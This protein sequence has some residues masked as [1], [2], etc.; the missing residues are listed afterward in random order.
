A[1]PPKVEEAFKQYCYI[2]YMALMHAA[3]SKAHLRRE[4][5]AFVFTQD[6]LT[7]K[8]L[9]RSN[10]LLIATVDW[11]AA[12]KA[13]EE[14]TLHYWG[15]DRSS[16]LT[17]HHL[18]VLDIAL[19]QSISHVPAW[20]G[21]QTPFKQILH[22]SRPVLPPKPLRYPV[23]LILTLPP[24]CIAATFDVSS[25]YRII[26]VKPSQQNALCIYWKGIVYVDRA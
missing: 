25:A 3:R 5:S 11:I 18:V 22:S 6:G 1:I 4:D 21:P 19:N 9:D 12:A 24:G 13:A 2:P 26:P 16:A 14:R 10:E 8:G 15:E 17:S 7:A 20:F 23:T